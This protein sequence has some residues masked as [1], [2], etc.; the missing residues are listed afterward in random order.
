MLN[1]LLNKV[2]FVLLIPILAACETPTETK[3]GNDIFGQWQLK[4]ISGGFAGISDTLD[5]SKD[6][7]IISFKY[8]NKFSR[9][10][11]DTLT[12]EGKFKVKKAKTIFSSDSLNIIEYYDYSV[13][14]NIEND[15]I[16]YLANDTLIIGDNY[17]D[18][19]SRLY[20]R[21]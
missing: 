8:G 1:K 3:K 20:K 21:K 4:V 10:Y 13:N 17:V 7:Y 12:I 9:Y 18:G 15:V 14:I 2:S 5:I 16:G 6:N 11:N 19:F